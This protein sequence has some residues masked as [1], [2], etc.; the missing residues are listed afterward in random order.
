MGENLE[1]LVTIF[2][3]H[4][5]LCNQLVIEANSIRLT[6]HLWVQQKYLQ[7][8]RV[9]QNLSNRLGDFH[10]V[11]PIDEDRNPIYPINGEPGFAFNPDRASPIMGRIEATNEKPS[12]E[13]SNDLTYSEEDDLFLV[14]CWM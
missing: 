14:V 7:L 8:E 10:E 12:Q 5:T 9:Q 1:A 4:N 11:L 13:L 3:E 6:N 2:R